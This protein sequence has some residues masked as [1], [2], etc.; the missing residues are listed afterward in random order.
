MST[1]IDIIPDALDPLYSLEVYSGTGGF[2][3]MIHGPDADNATKVW[4]DEPGIERLEDA[5]LVYKSMHGV[6]LR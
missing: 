4:L 6:K 1:P 3:L 5:V 2:C